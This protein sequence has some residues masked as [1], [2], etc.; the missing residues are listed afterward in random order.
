MIFTPLGEVPLAIIQFRYANAIKARET[1]RVLLVVGCG[2]VRGILHV[3][4]D[5][6]TIHQVARLL[7][8]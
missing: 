2:I 6:F 3:E 5:V 7:Y 4:S 8:V 1:N